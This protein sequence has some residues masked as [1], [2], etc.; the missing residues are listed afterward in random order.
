MKKVFKIVRLLVLGY[1]VLALLAI[2]RD[3]LLPYR[4]DELDSVDIES[5]D[6][7]FGG[8]QEHHWTVLG[9][10]KDTIPDTWQPELDMKYSECEHHVDF[11]R[12][13]CP[14]IQTND[15]VGYTLPSNP[16]LH[17]VILHHRPDGRIY[18]SMWR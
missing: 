7:D 13:H 11:F 16:S 1:I 18:V 4:L 8:L 12:E 6:F 9:K 3:Y 17:A 15:V 5:T 10:L 14:D 2:L